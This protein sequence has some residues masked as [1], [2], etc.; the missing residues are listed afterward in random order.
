MA[1]GF[2][3]LSDAAQVEYKCTDYY[4]PADEG[5]LIWNDPDVGITWPVEVPLLSEKDARHPRFVELFGKAPL[6]NAHL[7]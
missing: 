5:G 2:C 6:R 7:A 4:D 1:H 3:V